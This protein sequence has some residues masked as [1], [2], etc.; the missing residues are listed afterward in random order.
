MSIR[1]KMMMSQVLMVIAP[2]IVFVIAAY[3]ILSFSGGSFSA[4]KEFYHLSDHEKAEDIVS[5]EAAAVTGLQSEADSH[6][7]RL[8][9]GSRTASYEKDLEKRKI[10]IT[11][12]KDKDIV[13]RSELFSDRLAEKFQNEAS[14]SSDGYHSGYITNR[15]SHYMFLSRGLAFS[16]GTNGALILAMDITP[17]QTF[18]QTVIPALCAA[19]ILSFAVVN[20]VI[21]RLSSKRMVG[22]IISLKTSAGA[23]KE[24]DLDTPIHINRNDELGSLGQSFDDMR[25]RLKQSIESQQAAEK[26]RK[27][28]MANVSHDLKTPITSIKGYVEGILDG[29]AKDEKMREKYLRTIH[30]KAVRMDQLIDELFLYSKLDLV[31]EPFDM[32]KLDLSAFLEQLFVRYIADPAHRNVQFRFQNELNAPLFI[33]GD[34]KKLARVADNIIENSEKHMDTDQPQISCILYENEGNAVIKIEDNG[35]G[36]DQTELEKVFDRFYRIDDSRPSHN[37]G[38]GLGLSIAKKI[39]EAHHGTIRAESEPGK[40][41]AMIITLPGT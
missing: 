17:L 13:R 6:P 22:A 25:I 29:V 8:L 5:H 32:G 39:I 35:I 3:L 41:T 34:P 19:L 38:G 31:K 1:T 26:N 33:T 27:E 9:N 23:I 11:V 4:I 36:M 37:G 21:S 16:D 18:V 20:I 2:T 40:G 14:G 15:G 10:G 28:L 24:G 12:V 7:D 30:E